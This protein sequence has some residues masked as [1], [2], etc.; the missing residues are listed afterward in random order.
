[1]VDEV[2]V[3]VN[4]GNHRWVI[5]EKYTLNSYLGQT[6]IIGKGVEDIYLT[7]E[8]RRIESK[9]AQCNLRGDKGNLVLNKEEKEKE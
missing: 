6:T 9:G 3:K 5:L 4:L 1:M 2:C 8:G 7:L